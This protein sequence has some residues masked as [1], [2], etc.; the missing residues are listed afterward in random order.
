MQPITTAQ[1]TVLLQAYIQQRHTILLAGPPGCG[2]SAIA[3]QAAQ[4]LGYDSLVLHP[5]T[6]DPTDFKG[7]P[8]V[9]K[10]QADFIPFGEFKRI[11]TATK[12]LVVIFDD[13]GHAPKA[14]QATLMQPLWARELNGKKIPDH[15]SF[16]LCSNRRGDKAGV[17][18]ILD[19]ILTRCHG[20]FEIKPDL[21]TFMA[22]W[23]KVG[24][25]PEVVG[26]LRNFPDHVF[27][28]KKS[29]DIENFPCYRTWD[30]AGD[31]LNLQLGR[32]HE[33]VALAG[34]LGEGV[35]GQFG[36]YLRTYRDLPDI[37]EV[38][39]NPLK[40]KLPEKLDI[41]HAL[42]IAVAY[43]TSDKTFPAIAQLVQRMEK[44]GN[45][46]LAIYLL[47]DC[48]S[49]WPECLQTPDGVKICQGKLGKLILSE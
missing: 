49:R 3:L 5:V 44:Q 32:E 22:Y 15:V 47:R 14:V 19:P 17:E 40:V 26:Y 12:P 46:E 30:F 45:E 25:R 43:R 16:V 13:L 41:I 24:K 2:K 1:A 28:A 9:E 39:K 42:C 8:W 34:A 35:A 36:T 27:Q 18:G 23:V 48:R 20:V 4:A 10:G 11:L 38:L 6:S 21:D 7:F 31:I 37:D 33:A 29:A